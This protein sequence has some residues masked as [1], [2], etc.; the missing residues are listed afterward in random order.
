MVNFII[1]ISVGILNGMF[2]SGAGQILVCYLIFM[3]KI[4]THLVRALSVSILFIS[5][6]FTAFGYSMLIHYD[7]TK[8]TLIVILSI[9][10]GYLGTKLMKKINPNI[11][12]LI[13]GILIVAL[14]SYR[15]FVGG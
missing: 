5:S 4:D 12:N 2:A 10:S 9:I 7:I 11:L 6:I 1:G 13:S 3:K 8:I 14:T 15:A